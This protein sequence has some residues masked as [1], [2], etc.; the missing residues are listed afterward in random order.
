[1]VEP[2]PCPDSDEYNNAASAQFRAANPAHSA[3]VS[4]NAGS[5]KTKV[6]IDRVARLLL[7]GAAPDSILCVTYTK[8]A[9]NEML[10]RLFAQLG[11]W[12]VLEEA[13]L[14]T[15]LAALENRDPKGYTHDELRKARALFAKALETP[16]GLRIETIHAFCSRILRRFP[17][18]A[19]VAPGFNEID[20]SQADL[21]WDDALKTGILDAAENSRQVLDTVALAGGGLGVT[22]GLDTARGNGKALLKFATTFGHDP[23]EMDAALRASLKAPD[24]DEETLIAETMSALPLGE[25]GSTV[26]I[27]EA[28]GGSGAKKTAAILRRVFETKDPLEK[29]NIYRTLFFTQTGGPRKTV[30][31]KAILKD[32]VA[33][34]LFETVEIPEGSEILR[35]KK[36][37][38]DIRAARLYARTRALVHLSLPILQHYQYAKRD[39]AALDFEDLIG[40]THQL[41]TKADAANWV[42]YK[43]DGGLTHVLLDEAQDTS[44]DQWG[45]LN[46]LTGE[47]FAGRGTERVQDPRTLFVVGDEKQSIYSFQG[48]DPQKFLEERRNFE[49]KARASFGTAELPEMTMS[50]RSSPEILQF[51]DQVSEAGDV[52]G[53]PYIAGPVAEANL[54]RHTARRSN[55][56]GC[57]EL[58]PIDVPEA[59]EEAIPA[60][61]PRDTQAAD[62][63]KNK[64]ARKVACEISKLIDRREMIWTEDADRRWTYRPAQAGDV[65]ILVDKRTGGLFDALI[66]A[67]K[68][69]GIPVAGA[70]R[71]VLADHIGVQD[72]LNL[73]RFTLLPQDDLTLAEILR[74][75]FAN[76]VDDDEHLFALAHKRGTDTLWQRLQAS[77]H[78]AHAP[79]C[80]FL[81]QLLMWRTL[82]AYEFLCHVLETMSVYGHTGWDLLASRLG[83]P[84]RDP[85]QAL[86]A[87]AMAY[88]AKSAAS[89]QGFVAS[90]EGDQS[91]IKR[92]LAAPNGEVRVMT[93]HGAKGLQAPIVILPDTTRRPIASAKAMVEIDGAPVWLSKPSDDTQLTERSREHEK[94]RSGRERR[95]LLYVALTRAQ[96]RLIIC[97]AWHGTRPKPDKEIGPGYDKASWYALCAEAMTMLDAHCPINEATGRP[98]TWR[99]GNLPPLGDVVEDEGSQIES[100]PDWLGK[101]VPRETA[102]ARLLAPT[103]LLA[104]DDAPV[105][106][107]MGDERAARLKRGR[108]IHALLERLPELPADDRMK[109]GMA[110]LEQDRQLQPDARKEMLDA[111]MGV[112]TDPQF[113]DVFAEGGRPEA[114]VIGTAPEL[115]PG[116]IING[117]VDR[118][119]VTP[120]DVLIVDFK[121][122]RPPPKTPDKVGMSYLLQM[123][124]YSAVLA[125]AYPNRTIRSALVWTDGPKLMPLPNDLL[126]KALSQSSVPV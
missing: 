114:P 49:A 42:L 124:A 29:W 102:P 22:S 43:L 26:T 40:L 81:N 17:L 8:A 11:T 33:A 112:L 68:D 115:P 34:A 55:Q 75:P 62:S 120:T 97:G 87:R 35:A 125:K 4:A 63:P 76:L 13:A 107:P 69:K 78:P 86:L 123:A 7:K 61:A 15:K 52:E 54:S 104:P 37:D 30:V 88:D 2:I 103:S 58:W 65:L 95:R 56:A 99:Y 48:A 23:K 6:L 57:V 91:Q 83:P 67:L 94:L 73:I 5:G 96:D 47:F 119:I 92:D 121:T 53:H 1:M 72:C 59:E 113:D 93:V 84:M 27:L 110:F 98:E 116:T 50:F 24:A 80:E 85:V 3:W 28:N 60:E 51:V 108:L 44:P 25:L 118:L 36:L 64:L 20:D 32:P 12:S 111:A 109:A 117:R 18:E 45:L 19:N 16:G 41:L 106:P 66:D 21:F 105:L 39:H 122:D 79:V 70:D 31:T 74:G 71:L 101:P 90:M 46:A 82:P 10:E 126:E 14:K 100:L 89:L 9:A 38:A 77:T